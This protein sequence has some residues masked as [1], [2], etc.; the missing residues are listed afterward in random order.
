MP[1]PGPLI[2]KSSDDFQT[3]QDAI[4][5]IE[6]SGAGYRVDVRTKRKNW[7]IVVRGVSASS[8]DI[9]NLVNP[10]LHSCL[11]HACN[12]KSSRFEILGRQ[13]ESCSSRSLSGSYL[14]ELD[15]VI[16]EAVPR[17][18]H[19]PDLL[20]LDLLDSP[21]SSLFSFGVCRP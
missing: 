14:A 5:S 11:F 6:R 3:C 19:S 15:K 12:E 13:D 17:E 9:T 1:C 20:Q 7:E 18:M 21:I 10:D 2:V 16:E 4:A 8:D